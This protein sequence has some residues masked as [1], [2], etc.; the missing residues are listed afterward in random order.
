MS[1]E[2]S[3]TVSLPCNH[4]LLPLSEMGRVCQYHRSEF[5]VIYSL[6]VTQSLYY[7]L[8]IIKGKAMF[9]SAPSHATSGL[10]CV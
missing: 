7:A 4:T 6:S 1:N 5:Q 3:T 10:N 9:P 8:Y 2:I